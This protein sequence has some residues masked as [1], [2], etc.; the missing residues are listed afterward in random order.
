MCKSY[1]NVNNRILENF[2]PTP[3][4]DQSVEEQ[5]SKVELIVDEIIQDHSP[6]EQSTYT[7]VKESDCVHPLSY[8][9]GDTS[10]DTTGDTSID[11]LHAS[12]LEEIGRDVIRTHPYIT[13]FVQRNEMGTEALQRLQRILFLFAREHPD[14]GYVQGMNDILGTILYVFG[15]DE[16]E[17]FQLLLDCIIS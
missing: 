1:D 7:H 10:T 2:H 3:R 14:I 5:D 12:L 9:P 4:V 6:V 17:V 8:I 15:N 16:N 11:D 13:Y